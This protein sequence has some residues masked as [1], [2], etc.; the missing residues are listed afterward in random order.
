MT[1]KVADRTS[2]SRSPTAGCAMPPAPNTQIYITANM[3]NM[4][5]LEQSLKEL[6]KIYMV[7]S[8]IIHETSGDGIQ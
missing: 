1:N 7:D 4:N 6:P 2:F 3:M 5:E 8:R